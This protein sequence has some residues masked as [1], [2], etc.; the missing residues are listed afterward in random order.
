VKSRPIPE[1]KETAIALNSSR[2]V[3]T[4]AAWMAPNALKADLISIARSE[5]LDISKLVGLAVQRYTPF[6]E[7]YLCVLCHFVIQLDG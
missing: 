6:Y 4:K 3:S 5:K 2:D 7:C 1:Y